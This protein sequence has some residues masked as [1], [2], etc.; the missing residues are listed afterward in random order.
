M[1]CSWNNGDDARPFNGVSVSLF[2]G[3]GDVNFVLSRITFTIRLR[4]AFVKNDSGLLQS[5][6]N[7]HRCDDNLIDTQ[8]TG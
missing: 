8:V 3:A 6:S 7:L 5:M 4:S 2:V 1:N